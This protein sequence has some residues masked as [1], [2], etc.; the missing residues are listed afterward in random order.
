[1][2]NELP[3]LFRRFAHMYRAG[4]FNHLVLILVLQLTVRQ[5]LLRQYI[6]WPL[7]SSR[8]QYAVCSHNDASNM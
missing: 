5:Y 2:A 3:Q 8:C 1:M 7:H 6:Y 4:V